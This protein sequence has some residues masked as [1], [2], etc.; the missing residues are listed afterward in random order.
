MNAIGTQLTMG[1]GDRKKYQKTCPENQGE[2]VYRLKIKTFR[3]M[4]T[5]LLSLCLMLGAYTGRA[6]QQNENVTIARK[7]FDA[8]NAHDW[9]KMISYYASHATFEDPSFEKPVNDLQFITKHHE[10]LAAYFPD[11][12]DHVKAIYPSG[13][14]VIVEFVAKGTS[15]KGEPFSLPICTVLTFENGKVVRDATYYDNQPGN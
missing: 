14:N 2:P 4:K 10:E 6:Q 9:Q 11:I 13:K 8:F 7:I 15:I 12:Q 3:T 1:A 5:M